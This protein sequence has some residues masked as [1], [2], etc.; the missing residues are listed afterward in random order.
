MTELVILS[1]NRTEFNETHKR[2]A[3]GDEQALRELE[4]LWNNYADRALACFL[5]DN[6]VERPVF[7]LMLPERR[8]RTKAIAVPLC[9]ACRALPSMQRLGRAI[10]LLKKMWGKGTHFTF[11]PRRRG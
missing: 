5:C 1:L 3:A 6:E 10:K 7:T 9:L 11:K 2:A 4:Q 8:D